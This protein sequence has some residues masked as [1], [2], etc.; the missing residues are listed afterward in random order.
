MM[1]GR[2][3]LV[4]SHH[5]ELAKLSDVVHVLHQG[6]IVESGPHDWLIANGEIYRELHRSRL[7]HPETEVLERRLELV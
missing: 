5:L 4:I 2:A 3:T 7:S 6:R 1:S